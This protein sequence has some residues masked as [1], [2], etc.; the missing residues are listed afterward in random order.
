MNDESELYDLVTQTNTK[1]NMPL[2]Y[3]DSLAGWLSSLHAGCY[4]IWKSW[5]ESQ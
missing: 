5:V 4:P 2:Y 1:Q 3:I